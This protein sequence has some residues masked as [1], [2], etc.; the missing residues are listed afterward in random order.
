MTTRTATPPSETPAPPEAESFRFTEED[1]ALL[2][3]TLP[4]KLQV[5]ADDT[6]A[7]C[8][9][10]PRLLEE[11]H[12]GRTALIHQGQLINIWDTAE[13]ATQA[14][15]DKYG[16]DRQFSTPPIKQQQLDR[17]K[18]FLRQERAKQCPK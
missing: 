14:G 17:L 3:S 1:L 2:R 12:E 7:W 5:W 16:L 6:I 11:G 4:D 18:A 13:D 15:L 10:L 8:R 9:E